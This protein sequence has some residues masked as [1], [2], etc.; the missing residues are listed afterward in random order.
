MIVSEGPVKRKNLLVLG[1]ALAQ[2]ACVGD[3]F[4]SDPRLKPGMAE[5]LPPGIAG[6]TGKCSG[7]IAITPSGDLGHGHLASYLAVYDCASGK[8]ELLDTARAPQ[9]PVDFAD[10]NL[11][12]AGYYVNEY[13]RV[14]RTRYGRYSLHET[15]GGAVERF[16]RPDL[17]PHD[18]LVTDASILYMKYA[19][20]KAVFSRSAWCG[21]H[22][23]ELELVEESR[24]RA[25]LW[26]WSSVG[27]LDTAW[28]VPDMDPDAPV[29]GDAWKRGL[30]SVRN[31]YTT[32]LRKIGPMAVPSGFILSKTTP[33]FLLRTD[34]YIHANSIA[35][36]GPDGDILVSARNLDSIFLVSR[37]TG[38]VQW[39]LVGPMARMPGRKPVGDPRGGFSHQHAASI[40]ADKLY[41]FDNGDAF[42]H[43]PSR[44][45]V[46][47]VDESH[48]GEA[49]FKREYP[50]PNGRRRPAFGSVQPIPGGRV[51]IGW[52]ATDAS[53]EKQVTRA[54]SI[55]DAASGKEEFSIDFAA[56]WDSYRARFFSQ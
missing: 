30:G 48:L 38:A 21:V 4:P 1:L 2:A 22:P 14:E 36:V 17:D 54:V 45:V 26:E 46:Y 44:A 20:P 42:P 24:G 12:P 56:G 9:D 18:L 6:V 31:C 43:L 53:N 28:R 47:A 3:D 32:L 41:V 33:L 16:E 55:V 23:A 50:E 5:G 34:D 39:A 8:F 29:P 10:L 51:L 35:R 49:T 11:T 7:K 27:K 25:T 40:V 19:T 52:G 37:K 13:N 15:G